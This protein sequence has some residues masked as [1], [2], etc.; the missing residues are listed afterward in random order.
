MSLVF[1]LDKEI[2]YCNEL[3]ETVYSYTF[4]SINSESLY[5]RVVIEPISKEL[6]RKIRWF[7]LS[8][9][10]ISNFFFFFSAL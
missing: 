7:P 4:K 8:L 2:T 5:P 1:F 3:C 10:L 9:L 6:L